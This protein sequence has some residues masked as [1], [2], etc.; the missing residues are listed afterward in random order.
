[1][2]RFS[3]VAN[4]LAAVFTLLILAVAGASAQ[5]V[6]LDA[7]VPSNSFNN[8]H[9]AAQLDDKLYM[10]GG[11]SVPVGSTS[12]QFIARAW[13]L[14]LK[15]PNARWTALEDMPTPRAGG[16]AAAVN[17][18]IYIVGGYY[19]SGSVVTTPAVLEFDPKTGLFTEKAMMPTPSY[20]IAGAVIG[21]KIYAMGGISNNAYSNRVQVYDVATDTW[22]TAD[23][24]PVAYGYATA[25]ALGNS[26]Y[27]IG[28]VNTSAYSAGVY[29]GEVMDGAITWSAAR[30]L[31]TALTRLGSGVIGNNIY[32]AGGT[33]PNGESDKCYKYDA[34]A[35]TWTSSYSLPLVTYNVSHLPTDGKSIYFISGINNVNTYKFSEG[36]AVPVANINPKSLDYAVKTGTSATKPITIANNGVVNLTGNVTIS[37]TSPWLT[38]DG[39][40]FNVTAGS[41]QIIRVTANS[42]GMTEG[43]Y[44][45]SL[46]ITTND[47]DNKT[48]NIP[49]TLAVIDNVA[50]RRPLLEVFTSSTCGPCRPGNE[51]LHTVLATENRDD[52]TV[53]KFQQDFPGTGDPYCTDETVARRNFYA[54]NSIPRMEVDG[55]WDQNAQSFTSTVMNNYRD[56]L[57]FLNIDI[58]HKV[59]GQKVTVSVTANPMK[60]YT[61]ATNRMFVALCEKR[62]VK[63]IKSNG[64]TEFLDVVKKMLPDVNGLVIGA[65]TKGTPVTKTFEF[66]FQGSYRLPANGQAA[67]R[68]NHATEN[69]VESFDSFE[70]VAWIQDVSTKEVI[71]SGW[72]KADGTLDADDQPANGGVT[73]GSIAPNP[74]TGLAA[75]SYTMP[76]PGFATLDVFNTMGIKVASLVN[77]FVGQG[78]NTVNFDAEKLPV[79]SYSVVLTSGDHTSIRTLTIV[80]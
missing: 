5:W 70:V 35:N 2:K 72:S 33:G 13:Y 11:L 26:L 34:A 22:S 40:T 4:Q 46:T 47:E 53:V 9:M 16:Y 48:V 18:K 23:N 60:D 14:D 3:S 68:I 74:V 78:L 59:V 21:T 15:A 61:S 77:G 43:N 76:A 31:P 39:S 63:N 80:R 1:M 27:Y 65:M 12:G 75:F 44:T 7:T 36:A 64:E 58:K 69:S 32:V 49:V 24:L 45:G 54:I 66:E 57:S 8:W 6:K 25:G 56:V 29:K 19:S 67:S 42:V 79:G 17:G 62:T 38:V 28:G 10:F 51:V 50:K 30:T 71:N 20:Q 37:G 52:Y 55:K 41:S 73:I